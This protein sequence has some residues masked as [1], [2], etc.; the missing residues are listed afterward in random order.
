MM[1]FFAIEEDKWFSDL[2]S[3]ELFVPL[4][5]LICNTNWIKKGANVHKA[6]E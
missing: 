4:P 5:L 2:T 6:K 3:A 1:S